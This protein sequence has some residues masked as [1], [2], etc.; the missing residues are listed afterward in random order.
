MLTVDEYQQVSKEAFSFLIFSS[1]LSQE[2]DIDQSREY[3]LFL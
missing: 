3:V 1:G 2:D